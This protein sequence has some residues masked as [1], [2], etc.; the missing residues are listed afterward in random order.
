M[1]PAEPNP[2]SAAHANLLQLRRRR[3]SSGASPSKSVVTT[4]EGAGEELG[5]PLGSPQRTIVMPGAGQA[6]AFFGDP[7]STTIQPAPEVSIPPPARVRA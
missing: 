7:G 4:R 5:H 1:P 2:Q 6:G 3:S